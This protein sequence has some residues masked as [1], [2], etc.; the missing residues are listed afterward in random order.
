MKFKTALGKAVGAR[1][2]EKEPEA[3]QQVLGDVGKSI[4]LAAGSHLSDELAKLAVGGDDDD[5]DEQLD[6]DQGSRDA[7]DD[8]IAVG[9]GAATEEREEEGSSR[10]DEDC[11]TAPV[12]CPVLNCTENPTLVEFEDHMAEKHTDISNR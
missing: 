10:D 11:D 8:I 2:L 1:L 3:F 4:L 6:G 7:H 9:H 5:D 12:V